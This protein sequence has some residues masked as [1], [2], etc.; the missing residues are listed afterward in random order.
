MSSLTQRSN[1]NK[2]SLGTFKHGLDRLF[3]D[4]EGDLLMPLGSSRSL[5]PFSAGSLSM[6]VKETASS[7]S[8]AV[9]VPGL[10]KEDISISVDESHST[11]SIT[12][13]RKHQKEEKD[14]GWLLRERSYGK[15]QRSV[16][17]PESADLNKAEVELKVCHI[18]RNSSKYHS[19]F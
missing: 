9:E 18:C 3:R 8:L 14:D 10:S 16:Q 6:D 4:M 2:Q 5:L 13:E 15:C 7:Y 1:S 12:A 19:S 17:L 11:L